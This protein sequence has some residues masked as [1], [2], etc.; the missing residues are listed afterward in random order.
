[1]K[2]IGL[3]LSMFF[4][5]MLA[6]AGTAAAQATTVDIDSIGETVLGIDPEA[7]VEAL[8]E[9]PDDSVLPDGF[10][11]PESGTPAN[12]ELV[13]AFATPLGDLEGSVGTVTHGLDTDPSVVPGLVSAGIITYIVVED[14]ITSDDLDDFEAGASEGLESAATESVE[15][16]VDRIDVEGNDAVQIEVITTQDDIVSIVQIVALP[17]GNTMVVGTVVVADQGEVDGPEVLDLAA[18]LGI[19]GAENLGL[20]AEAAA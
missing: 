19:A 12:E 14:E 17:V 7:L 1:M 13:T 15:A 9:A 4:A 6:G 5:L 16:S 18:A 20:V 3:I 2:R 11:N 10:M 8:S